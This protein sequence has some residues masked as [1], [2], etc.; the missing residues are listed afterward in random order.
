[1]KI[2]KMIFAF[3]L[4]GFTL[5]AQQNN[6]NDEKE[7]LQVL[8]DQRIA[9]NKGDITEYMKGYW[10]SDSLMFIGKN[11][12]RYGWNETLNAYKKGY[13]NKEAM[14]FLEFEVIKL[15]FFSSN[16]AF[17]IGKWKLTRTID[18]IAGY[19]TLVW[20]KIKNEWII[21]ADHSS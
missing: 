3:I 16:S 15:E 2:T 18:N 9:W 14:G 21:V 8:E 12:I 19:F 11:G 7:I 4:V 17:M 1:M 13:P 6:S 5:N 10:N 20:K